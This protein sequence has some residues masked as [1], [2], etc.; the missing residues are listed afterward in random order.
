VYGSSGGLR[1]IDD[2]QI[3][4][5]RS[6][7][8]D[9]PAILT[10]MTSSI[11][12]P[13]YSDLAQP[14]R[15][16]HDGEGPAQRRTP[17]SNSSLA[18]SLSNIS[19]FMLMSDSASSLFAVASTP[20]GSRSIS[21]HGVFAPAKGTDGAAYA[22]RLRA[23]TSETAP[24]N[25]LDDA[26]DFLP[27]AYVPHIAVYASTDTDEFIKEKGFAQGLWELLR[28]FGEHVQ[29]KV[30][31]RDSNN[32][33]R[34]YD[35]FA[36]RFV[37]L[38]G[39][40]DGLSTSDRDN[41]GADTGVTA[42]QIGGSTSNYGQ[43]LP[44]LQPVEAAG[45]VELVETLVDKYVED[46]EIS[47]RPSMTESTGVCSPAHRDSL[48]SFYSLYLRRLLTGLRLAPHET[49]AHPVAC[50][51]AISSRNP[52]PIEA[53]RRLYDDSSRGHK[54][55]PVWVNGEY[56]RYYVLVHDE[57]RDDV[58]K[59][60]TLFEQMKRHFGL[61]CHLL[62]L[63]SSQC[64]ITDDDSVSFPSLEWISAAEELAQIRAR[65]SDPDIEAPEPCIFES[66]ATAIQAFVR[67][68]LTQSVIPHM[69][70]CVVTWNEIASRRRGISGKLLGITKKWS[71]GGGSRS[72]GNGA[73][74]NYDNVQGYYKPDAPEA[75]MRK[76]ADYAFMLRDWK[77]AQS[78]YDIVRG[79]YNSDKAW[80]YHAA[81]NEM[82][83]ISSL[84]LAQSVQSKSRLE[85]VDQMIETAVYSYITRCGAPYGALRCLMLSVELLR[86]REGRPTDDAARWASRLLESKLT[87]PIG[88]ALIM[89]RISTC[90]ES[91]RGLGSGA[92]G[93]R[94]RKAAMWRV[95]AGAEWVGLEKYAQARNQ[96]LQARKLYALLPKDASLGGFTAASTFLS[97]SEY[98]LQ[99][100][101]SIGATAGSTE[102]IGDVESSSIEE[103]SEA[104]DVRNHRK[105]LIGSTPPQMGLMEGMAL[106]AAVSQDG[107]DSLV[108]AGFE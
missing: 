29:G 72:P 90:F 46:A 23:E 45:Q 88:E 79:D 105:S 101:A 36:V 32:T 25:P 31:V 9:G 74:S 68:M 76:L 94:L 37:Q 89:E 61:H 84:L 106:Q 104:L 85:L 18:I 93:S 53:L 66:D 20:P 103:E 73:N 78:V 2:L 35:D 8:N 67:E 27:H 59:S 92:W 98:E 86:L 95:L 69:E 11:N 39:D 40:G 5:S 4:E 6:H 91:R 28:P 44:G 24:L 60:L 57:E 42:G 80:E 52:N 12:A 63:R 87:G 34:V 41:G 102:A 33:S 13:S 47:F 7:R 58:G 22:G 15:L 26:R 55:L 71:L 64:V 1:G 51:M 21:P 77:L 17:E 75:T 48:S 19:Q 107:R 82:A 43:S 10:S 14:T 54:R 65:N 99:M 50:I 38:G 3:N 70:R 62:R 97:S 30:T 108:N 83:A 49:F 56:L 81:A 96:L 16:S 100:V